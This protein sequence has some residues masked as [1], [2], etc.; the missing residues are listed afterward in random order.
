MSAFPLNEC[1]FLRERLRWGNMKL[2]FPPASFSVGVL[3]S[4]VTLV[5]KNKYY[6]MKQLL[7]STT[8]SILN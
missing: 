7:K 3:S 5:F 2:H 6:H 8:L 4:H 1:V